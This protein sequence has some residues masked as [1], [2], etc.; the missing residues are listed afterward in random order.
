ML[1]LNTLEQYLQQYFKK[2]GNG[3]KFWW[4]VKW[5]DHQSGG[6]NPAFHGGP[7]IQGAD[8]PL[9]CMGQ[10]DGQTHNSD[11]MGPYIGRRSKKTFILIAVLFILQQTYK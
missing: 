3:V 9:H 1:T 5:V 4:E 6:W 8:T 2:W 7:Y 10:T 11:V